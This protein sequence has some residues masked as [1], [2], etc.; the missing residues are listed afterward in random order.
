MATGP[1]VVPGREQRR[2]PPKD[3]I[4]RSVRKPASHSVDRF[5][6]LPLPIPEPGSSTNATIRYNLAQAA[7]HTSVEKRL[8]ELIESSDD[9][10][11]L[12]AMKLFYDVMMVKENE[13]RVMHGELKPQIF[14][15]EQL[16][17][18]AKV[19]NIK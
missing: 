17:D 15:P 12:Q 8:I 19:V 16:P 10:V 4:N 3:G 18:P 2:P 9:K 1:K 7:S 13:S 5:L 14:L 11:A 6:K